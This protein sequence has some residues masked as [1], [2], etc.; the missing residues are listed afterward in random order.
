MVYSWLKRGHKTIGVAKDAAEG[1]PCWNITSES[2]ENHCSE[3]VTAPALNKEGPIRVLDNKIPATYMERVHKFTSN[4]KT[5][6]TYAVVKMMIADLTR[7]Q[8]RDRFCKD[9][10]ND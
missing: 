5:P 8:K 6:I 10:R 9:I 4:R 3:G 2:E 7:K 1:V